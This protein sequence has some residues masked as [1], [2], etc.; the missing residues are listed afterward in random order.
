[1]WL[2]LC[3][4][5]R[6]LVPPTWRKNPPNVQILGFK[7]G[8]GFVLIDGVPYYDR[9]PYLDLSSNRPTTSP[10]LWLPKG[11]FGPLRRWRLAWGYQHHHQKSHYQTHGFSYLE[12]GE[13]DTNRES[14]SA[15]WKKGI[16]SGWLGNV[17]RKLRAG[18][19]G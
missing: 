19:F 5:R 14:F 13:N 8:Q 4:T 7:S 10:K 1:M 12:M 6:V 2:S 16:F 3:P 9:V 18:G 11:P 15:G 17:M